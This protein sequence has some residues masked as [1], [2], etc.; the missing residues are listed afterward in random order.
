MALC[1]TCNKNMEGIRISLSDS[2]PLEFPLNQDIFSLWYYAD[3][4][5]ELDEF[6]IVYPSF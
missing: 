3:C 5:K 4:G 6:I 1:K 2:P